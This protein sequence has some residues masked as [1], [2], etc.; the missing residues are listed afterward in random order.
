[1][2]KNILQESRFAGTCFSGEEYIP[3]GLVDELDRQLEHFIIG[4]GSK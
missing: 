2:I 1:M 3:V 4:I